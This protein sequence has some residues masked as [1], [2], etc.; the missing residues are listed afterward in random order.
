MESNG[1]RKPSVYKRLTQVVEGSP[2]LFHAPKLLGSALRTIPIPARTK[3]MHP[4]EQNHSFFE[5]PLDLN[6]SFNAID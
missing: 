6:N 5:D 1:N 4:A 3:T 2:V